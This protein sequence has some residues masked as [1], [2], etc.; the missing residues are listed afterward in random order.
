MGSSDSVGSGIVNVG[1]LGNRLW[2]AKHGGGV[3]ALGRSTY[4]EAIL[5]GASSGIKNAD[6]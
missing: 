3:S 5:V 2:G 6:R 4:C 1:F